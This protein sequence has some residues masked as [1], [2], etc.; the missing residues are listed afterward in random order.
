MA[1]N[2]LREELTKEFLSVLNEGEIPWEASW[3]TSY[4]LN[5]VTGKRYRG[6]N[7]LWLSYL[8]MF[9][10]YSDPRWCTFNQAK[11]NGWTVKKGEKSAHIEFWS[12]YD[13]KTKKTIDR[14]EAA[15]IVND[16]PN[17]EKD[18]ILMSRTYC[19]FN[20][21][22]I[23]GIPEFELQ[24]NTD[25]GEIRA[26]RDV[27]LKNMDLKFR[28]GGSEAYYTPSLDQVTLPPEATFFDTYGYMSTFLHECGHASG[29]E[30]RLNRDLSGGFGSESYAKEELRAEIASAFTAQDLG[31]GAG[32]TGRQ[33]DIRNHKAYVQ[34]WAKVIQS[35]PNELFAAMRFVGGLWL[36]R[37]S[38]VAG[39]SL[40]TCNR[41]LFAAFTKIFSSSRED[42][43]PS[44]ATC[45]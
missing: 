10:G 2:K 26:K 7:S 39:L 31:L 12:L 32:T 38:R 45:L 40:A 4:P 13:K 41:A 3:K 17:R 34:H 28:E 43:K 36:T 9:K 37:Q 25:I 19:V 1:T 16:D 14:S 27:L 15:R 23:D 42:S 21:Q 8:A 30:T 22:Q 24:S 18:I 11:D 44:P 5:A 33:D 20:A 29:H 35:D 6:V